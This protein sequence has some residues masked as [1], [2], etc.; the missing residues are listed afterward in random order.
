MSEKVGP[1]DIKRGSNGEVLRI[2]PRRFQETNYVDLRVWFPGA[3]GE[4]CP[5]KKG[6]CLKASLLDEVIGALEAVRDGIDE[7]AL[8]GF[9]DGEPTKL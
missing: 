1:V 8:E 7:S 3:N 4:M 6:V 5:T 9:E 2:N